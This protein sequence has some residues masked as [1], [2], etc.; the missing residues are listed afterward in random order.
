VIAFGLTLSEA[1][2]YRRYSQPGIERAAEPDSAVF[3]LAAVSSLPRSLNLVLDAAAARS[4]LE[5]LVLLHPHTELMDPDLCARVRGILADPDVAVA[6]AAGATGV[7]HTIAWWEGQTSI[8]SGIH[9]YEGFA[10]GEFPAFSWAGSA[11]TG[12]GEVDA[13]DGSLLVLSPWAVRSIRFDE[14]LRFG[15]GYDVDYCRQVRAAG[16]KV[17]T[18]DLRATYHMDLELVDE[19]GLWIEAHQQV[20]EKWDEADGDEAYWRARARRAEAER[21]AARAIANGQQLTQDARVDL[22]EK[23]LD[24]TAATVSWRVTEPL[25]VANARRRRW[26][27]SRR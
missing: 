13:V 19:L 23:R 14:A 11:G 20:A 7:D 2:A 6:G 1:E 15:H 9:R 22:L 16:R 21:E 10:G 17:V 18:A 3:A 12:F 26:N 5:A 8:A 27:E 25:R 24:A 4:D